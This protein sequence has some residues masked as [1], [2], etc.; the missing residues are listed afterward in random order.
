MF[1]RT[2][3]TGAEDRPHESRT[4]AP[5][6]PQQQRLGAHSQRRDGLRAHLHRTLRW[7]QREHPAQALCERGAVLG[8]KA[9]RAGREAGAH[10]WQERVHEPRFRCQAPGAAAAQQLERRTALL[11]RLQGGARECGGGRLVSQ[12]LE[13]APA[14]P[15]K[16]FLI[17]EIRF[18]LMAFK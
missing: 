4:F 10:R 18:I 13:G 2:G 15:S 5:S 1:S 6:G 16:G 7:Q 8:R 17:A 3:H 11:H 9:G 12:P 14:E